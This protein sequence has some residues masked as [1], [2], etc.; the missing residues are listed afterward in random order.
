MATP[1][2]GEQTTLLGNK[3]V[4]PAS[5]DHL[6]GA[7][8]WV[9]MGCTVL[10]LGTLSTYIYYDMVDAIGLPYGLALCATRHMLSAVLYYVLA[11]IY[12]MLDFSAE[13]M[14]I[15][16]GDRSTWNASVLPEL[17][18]KYGER[19]IKIVDALSRRSEH[20]F[21]CLYNWAVFVPFVV[22][23]QQGRV[24]AAMT[25]CVVKIFIRMWTIH[26]DG[27]IAAICFRGARIRDGRLGRWN[28]MVVYFV[29]LGFF[30]LVQLLLLCSNIAPAHLPA[31][32][33]YVWQPHIWGDALAELI[34]S[35]FGRMEFQVAGFG[36]INRKTVEG[37]MACWLASFWACASCSYIP[38]FPDAAF[39]NVPVYV[40]HVIVASFAT[41]M[42]TIC[43]RG[44]DNGFIVLSAALVVMQ[45]YNPHAQVGPPEMGLPHKL[46][47]VAFLG[48]RVTQLT[49]VT[50]VAMPFT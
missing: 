29:S 18:A 33:I 49:G 26:S 9:C 45:L 39:F 41:F 28:Q 38:G 10:F 1:T 6:V 21:G 35:F 13:D 50:F 5:G 3:A 20:V 46:Q 16:R 23:T 47:H 27:I 11:A 19:K 7:A 32:M 36:E 22:P 40:L 44:T 42:E 30:P 17:I 12:N 31:V 8:W 43:F 34:G 37:V 14:A 25:Y 48:P 15:I 2:A 24:L 4:E